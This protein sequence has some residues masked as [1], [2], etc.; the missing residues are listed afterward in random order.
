M[1]ADLARH[2]GRLARSLA[3]LLGVATCT[4]L[5][6]ADK[7]T[8][9]FENKM[10]MPWRSPERA[11][12]NF[13]LLK[14]VEAKVDVQFDFEK[15]P[16]KRCLAKLKSNQ[17]DGAF[18]VSFSDERRQYGVFPGNGEADSKMRMQ[19][20]RYFLVRKKGGKA[21]WDGTRFSQVDGRIAFQLG[22]SIAE[23]LQEQKMAVDESNDSPYNLGRKVLAGRVAAAAM[24]DSD[25]EAL[26]NGPLASQLEVVP[27]PLMEKPYYLMFSHSLVKARPDLAERIWASIEEVRNG[28]EYK[29]L[30]QAA[31]MEHAR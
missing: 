14:R 22:Y 15:L 2:T 24:F 11:G 9:C 5:L 17:V 10:V 7:L 3:A 8:L 31:G 13:E 16:W 6:A 1:P 12:L 30:V 29:K 23:M 28:R 25:V 19:M 20:A 26:M 18:S 4:P 27:A 21:N